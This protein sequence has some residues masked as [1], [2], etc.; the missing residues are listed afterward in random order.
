M[1]DP[2]I[3]AR[4]A[5]ALRSSNTLQRPLRRDGASVF[6]VNDV[7]PDDG[8]KPFPYLKGL[9]TAVAGPSEAR[10]TGSG[11]IYY[12]PTHGDKLIT[13]NVGE[14]Q[15][16][17]AQLARDGNNI[18]NWLND[19]DLLIAPPGNIYFQPG[20]EIMGLL[21]DYFPSTAGN[22]QRVG[23]KIAAAADADASGSTAA[24]ADDCYLFNATVGST[25]YDDGD[26]WSAW[27]LGAGGVAVDQI[28]NDAYMKGVPENVRFQKPVWLSKGDKVKV[29][30]H[31]VGAACTVWADLDFVR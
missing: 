22:S 3:S 15:Y 7:V 5:A 16:V 10:L 1:S 14:N 23:M 26:Y 31:N 12:R 30:Y 6:H 27:V 11:G 25:K 2:A 28:V 4:K 20:G 19:G 29:T 8:R 17:V 18:F 9:G 24:V 13:V 21:E